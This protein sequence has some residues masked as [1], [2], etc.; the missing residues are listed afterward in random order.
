MSEKQYVTYG[1]SCG[2][3]EGCGC[4]ATGA[5]LAITG[6]RF[7]L[8]VMSDRYI[9]IILSSLAKTNTGKVW[10][11]T[12]K[13]STVYR[14]KQVHVEDALQ[15]CFT[16]AYTPGVHMTME[17]TFSKGCPG[18]VDADVFMA[19]D[20]V[21]LNAEGMKDIHFPVAC[22]IALYPLGTGDYMQHIAHVVNHAIDLGIYEKSS[23]YCTILKGDVHQLFDYFHYVN[24]YCG[25][26][27]RHYVFEITL[28]VNSPTAD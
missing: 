1:Q 20:D 5:S 23:H 16:H 8:G 6:C 13:L 3:G 2:C 15:A 4:G 12:D 26:N 27:L 21:P 19:E 18:D 25:E 11:M 10:K 24:S 9:D 28:S 22:K 14:G 17:A 7:S